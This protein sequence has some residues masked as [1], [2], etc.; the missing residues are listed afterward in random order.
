MSLIDRELVRDLYV[1]PGDEFHEVAGVISG[2]PRFVIIDDEGCSFLL[3]LLPCGERTLVPI[4]PT[5]AT[6]H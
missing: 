4:L 2:L 1:E 3:T 6:M 5:N